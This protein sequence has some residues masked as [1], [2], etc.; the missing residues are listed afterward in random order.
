MRYRSALG[1]VAVVALAL[2]SISVAFA[3]ASPTTIT[4]HKPDLPPGYT[5]DSAKTVTNAQMAAQTHVAK[6]QFDRHGRII[7][8]EEQFRGSSLTLPTNI[9]ANVYAYKTAA[10]AGWD[11]ANTS[12]HDLVIAH[13]A[14]APRFGVASTGFTQRITSGGQKIDVFGITFHRGNYD[15]TVGVGGLAGHVNMSDAAKYA[16]IVDRRAQN[17]K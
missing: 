11:Y 9:F 8:Y 12:A 7:G 14:H 1:S 2:V 16:R 5:L 17:A 15:M 10:G 3:L 6:A 13:F 4:L